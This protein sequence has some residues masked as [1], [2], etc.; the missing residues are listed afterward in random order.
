MLLRGIV[1]ITHTQ[2][3]DRNLLI[4][5]TTVGAY[6]HDVSGCF[7]QAAALDTALR[8]RYLRRATYL[9]LSLIHI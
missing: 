9:T 1:S 5:E 4:G 6:M 7:L 3:L 8:Q 2:L